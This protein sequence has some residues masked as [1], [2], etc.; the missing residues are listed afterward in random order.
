MNRSTF[1]KLSALGL[2][3]TTHAGLLARW[4]SNGPAIVH[5]DALLD[6]IIERSDRVVAQYFESLKNYDEIRYYRTF[7]DALA[8]YAAS[9]CHPKSTYHASGEVLARMDSLLDRL[10]E[11]QYP[12]GTM[13]S[14]GNRQSPPDTAFF[15]EK[16][17]PAAEILK[18]A[19]IDASGGVR[20]KLDTFLVRAG[21][22]VRT[23]GIHT[24]N[25]RW[26]VS[27]MLARLHALFGD[28]KYLRRMDQWLAEGIY[29]NADGNYPERSRN[30]ALVESNAFVTIGRLLDRPELMEIARRNLV[31]TYYYLEPNGDLVTLDSRRQDQNAPLEMARYYFLYKY[32]AL[33]FK[34]D[35]LASIA[36]QIE[37]FPG[38]ERH[39]LTK[40]YAFMEDPILL[41]RLEP[42]EHPPT[43]Y[44]KS[45][46]GSGLVRIRRADTTA[47]IFGGNDKPI[48]V[49]SGRSNNPTLFTFRKGKAILHSVR[50][51]TTFFSMGYVRGDGVAIDGN[52]YALTERK[53]AYY[54]LPLPAD[55]RNPAGDYPL[56]ESL[57]GR[58]WSK[59]DFPERP[60]DTVVQQSTVTVAED[61]GAF[62]L[63]FDIDGPPDVDVTIECCFNQGG[64][65]EGVSPERNGDDYFLRSGTARYI[66]GDDVIE[67]GPGT[68]A[69]NNL[70]GLDGEAYSVHNG[71]IRGEG[72]HVYLTGRTPFRHTMTIR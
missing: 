15:L 10:L 55:K 25:H 42:R 16:M 5:D 54:Y 67:I 56:T 44:T 43:T 49:A 70:R 46:P 62:T 29:Q 7:S 41:G 27:A 61:N 36:N 23:G 72:M 40:L 38:F 39:A 22:A 18:Q 28:E 4:L 33:H 58:F 19:G 31:A 9:Y 68:Y 47:S 8:A 59:L 2:A 35:F 69:H 14:G 53:E 65:L 12:N 11:V 21:E 48:Q 71:T 66:A 1:L 37:E 30:Y 13:D 50:V 3:G 32:L 57:D 26:V 20:E 52:R 17:I 24:P 51:S 45:L 6:R 34:D 64:R 63:V 60:K